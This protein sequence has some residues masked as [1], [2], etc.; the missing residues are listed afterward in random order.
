[1]FEQKNFA[2]DQKET[3]NYRYP[4]D[5]NAVKKMADVLHYIGTD[6]DERKLLD[7]EAYWKRYDYHT[8]G[9][10]MRKDDELA[11]K[12][13]ELTE[14]KQQTEEAKQREEEAKQR[15]EEAKRQAEEAKRQKEDLMR[16]FA[17]NLKIDGTSVPKIAKLTGL[18][19]KEIEKL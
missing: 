17:V 16:K 14:A 9:A 19:E 3:I 12:D 15:E 2:D 11:K 13:R 4:L 1:M 5:D 8:V 18:S 10:L 6:P 7:E